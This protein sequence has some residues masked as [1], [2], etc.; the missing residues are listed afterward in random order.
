MQILYLEDEPLDA[1][2]VERYLR[3]ISSDIVLTVVKDVPSAEAA[4]ATEP[5]LFLVD[6]VLGSTRSGLDFVR[7]VRELGHQQKIIVITALT[8]LGD[9]EECFASGCTE[10]IAKP[11]NINELDRVLSRYIQA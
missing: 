1:Q 10:V 3:S 4:L 7:T 2:L 6:I 11:F 5:A 9:I 8:L